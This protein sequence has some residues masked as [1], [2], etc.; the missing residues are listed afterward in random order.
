MI[1]A[2]FEGYSSCMRKK[3]VLIIFLIIIFA[4]LL[5][6]AIYFTRPTVAFIE[7]GA[8]PND[9]AIPV[10]H[11]SLFH[12]RR[13]SSPEN[14]DLVIVAPDAAVPDGV[15]AYLLGRE[16]EDDESVLDTIRIDEGR[17]WGSVLD[18][19]SIALLYE[20]SSAAASDIS[21]YLHA[22]SP[23]IADVVY[24]GRISSA[25]IDEITDAL[26]SYETVF[27]LTPSSSMN[28]IN[29]C[30]EHRLVMNILDAAAMETVK[31]YKAVS[32]D[33]T[34]TIEN[35]FSGNPRAEYRVVTP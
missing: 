31:P 16:P 8:L 17:L 11:G 7:S 23:V 3:I 26:A 32:I 4:A 14:A 28:F 20:E 10:P 30:G 33:W 34:S 22:L 15:E 35:L 21:G 1:L 6:S 18:D 19:S 24:Q 2:A 27:C 13:V 5:L 12:Y 9:Y 25:N 29:N